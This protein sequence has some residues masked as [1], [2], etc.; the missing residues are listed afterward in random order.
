MVN[1]MVHVISGPNS[2]FA[3]RS[4]DLRRKKGITQEELAQCCGIAVRNISLY[5]SGHSIPRSGTLEKLAECLDC[6][7]YF[8]LHGHSR[9]T[10]EYLSKNK[11]IF[12]ENLIKKKQFLYINEW[13]RLA[14]REK[15]VFGQPIYTENP[16][17]NGHS[18]DLSLFIPYIA[19][20]FHFIA[21]RLPQNLSLSNSDIYSSYEQILIVNLDVV[22]EEEL[23]DGVQ[24]I[25]ASI[26]EGKLPSLGTV[27]R[28][29]GEENFFIQSIPN[30]FKCFEFEDTQY[31]ILGTVEGI[32]CRK[33]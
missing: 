18:S 13:E 17:S 31:K 5:E 4:R 14:L 26:D 27:K 11:K 2:H 32:I 10:K 7:S 22:S 3:M 19:P 16:V 24:V 33:I 15:I 25:Y 9:K 1:D 23:K 30:N 29:V 12:Q 6:D 28:E 21:V 8:L 20:I